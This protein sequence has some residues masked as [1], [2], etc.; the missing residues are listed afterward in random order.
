[1]AVPAWQVFKQEKAAAGDLV[2]LGVGAGKASCQDVVTKSA[3]GNND[4]RQEGEQIAYPDSPPAFGPHWPNFMQ[5]SELRSFY[6]ESDRPQ[7]ER[8]VHSL[9]HGHSIL[10]YDQT[11]KPGT[12]AYQDVKAIAEKFNAESDK[13]MAAPWNTD[14]GG[15]FPGGMHVALTHWT[16]PE[17]QKGITEYCK[18]PSGAVVQTFVKDYPA[19]NAPEPNA[20]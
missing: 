11:V 10:W 17:K 4:H 2:T 3:E 20:P 7:I 15:S 5:G 13:F 12:S 9:E 14:D 6:T 18:A 16:G 1:M 8:L 19:N